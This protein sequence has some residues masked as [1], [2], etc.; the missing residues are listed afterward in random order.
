[1]K[2]IIQT[3]LAIAFLILVM[4]LPS[5]SQT[6]IKYDTIKVIMLC[7]DTSTREVYNGLTL[8]SSINF[9]HYRTYRLYSNAMFWQFGYEVIE[10]GDPFPEIVIPV[11]PP[12]KQPE[13]KR[14]FLDESKKPVEKTLI[15]FQTQRL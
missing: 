6:S 13:P 8:D 1:M 9:I 3:I 5:R 15:I 10:L 14:I 2:F 11:W 4:C 12:I 7:A